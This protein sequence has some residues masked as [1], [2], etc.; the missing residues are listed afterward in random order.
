MYPSLSKHHLLS[1]FESQ[2]RSDR[3]VTYRKNSDMTDKPNPHDKKI[4]LAEKS[5]SADELYRFSQSKNP[6][7]RLA[8]VKN[9]KCTAKILEEMSKDNNDAVRTYIAMHPNTF[10]ETLSRLACDYNREFVQAAVGSNINTPSEDLSFIVR[11]NDIEHMEKLAKRYYRNMLTTADAVIKNDTAET[12]KTFKAQKER[13][14]TIT[15]GKYYCNNVAFFSAL[16]NPKTPKETRKPYAHRIFFLHH[17]PDKM[18]DL[19]PEGESLYCQTLEF[20]RGGA[21]PVE[22]EIDRSIP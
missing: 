12:R 21:Y 22:L 7:V 9:P 20:G 15:R 10:P 3:I 14:E 11:T 18:N 4:A 19:T 17:Q 1:P 6:Y 8:V 5:S 2:M 16:R 13:F